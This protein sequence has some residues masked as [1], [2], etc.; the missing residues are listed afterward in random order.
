MKVKITVKSASGERVGRQFDVD[1]DSEVT[2]RVPVPDGKE[3]QPGDKRSMIQ[4]L[5]DGIDLVM[6]QPNLSD[7]TS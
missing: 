5:A 1:S 7:A 6:P 4:R 2:I 3:P